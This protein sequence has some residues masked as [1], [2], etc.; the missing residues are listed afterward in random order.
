ML[1][2][3]AARA[4]V[5]DTVRGRV[6]AAVPN[7]RGSETIEFASDP[8]CALGRVVAEIV[9]ADREY[10]PFD[11]AMRDGYA[12]RAAEVT[13]PGARLRLIGESRAGFPFEGE[14]ALGTC[15]QIMTGAP[16]PRGTDSVV[17]IEHTKLEGDFVVFD[18]PAVAG[19]NVVRAG[20]ENH[21]GDALLRPGTRLG[22]PELAMAAQAGRTSISVSRKPRIAILSTGDEIVGV[23][24]TPGPFQ[25]R[26]SNCISLAAQTSLANAEPILLGNAPD[27]VAAIR[28]AVEKGLQADAL[29]LSGGVSAGK[30]DLVEPVLKELGAEFLFDAVAIR[31]GKPMVFA[32]CKGRP[33]FGLPGNPVSTMVTFELFV[34]PAIEIL[35]GLAPQPLPVL[36]AKVRRAIDLAAPLTHF[37]GARVSWPEGEPWVEVLPAE[38]SGDIG[39]LTRGNCYLVV[40]EAKR[41]IESGEWVDVLPRRGAL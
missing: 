30:Y 11:R 40:H 23:A 5:I 29:V 15:V 8:S 26:N 10:P 37:V 4:K 6:A 1:S 39:R 17:M 9:S 20:T 25:I 7:S 12:V 36:R 41:K 31:P 34:Q 38:S 22:F 14:L 3:E 2:F 13:A 16:A 24:E 33:V 32:L 27:D 28:T 19:K 21:A 18:R 35:S